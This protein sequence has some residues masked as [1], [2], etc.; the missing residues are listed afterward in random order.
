MSEKWK[1]QIRIEGGSMEE[2]FEML[3][4]ASPDCIKLFGLDNKLKY[5]SPGGLKEHG[6]K[7]LDEAI[8]FNWLETID[9][10]QQREVLAKIQE[11]IQK[12]KQVSID[13]KHKKGSADRECC[14]LIINPVFD[15]NGD[16]KYF[17]GISRDISDRINH[18]KEIERQLDENRRM[19]EVM[20]G[21]ELKMSE[22]KKEN[23]RLKNELEKLTE[24]Q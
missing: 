16:V 9:P 5:L 11:S 7:N 13:V 8:G 2:Y 19:N 17:V 23:M 1:D 22:L 14:H 6:F 20:V 18:Q 4:K 24:K 12:K 15:E 10:E 21:R 3:M